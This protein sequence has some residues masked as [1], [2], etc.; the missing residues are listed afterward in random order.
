M[1]NSL[2][3]ITIAIGMSVN[4]HAEGV[5]PSRLLLSSFANQCPQVVTRNVS[6]T[7]VNIQALYGAVEEIKKDTDCHGAASLSAIVGR[8]NSLYDD[9]ENQNSSTVDRSKLERQIALYATLLGDSS[10]DEA[11]KSFL[12]TEVISAQAELVSINQGLARFQNFS[13]REARVA[14]QLVTAVDDF[15]TE[16]QTTQGEACYAKHSAQISNI[17]SNALLVTAAF[18]SGGTS[19]A[20]A[21]GAV[22]VKSVGK[23]VGDFKESRTMENLNDIEMPTALRCVSQALS[24]QFCSAAETQELIS[25]RIDSINTS[26]NT[27]DGINLLS[28]QLNPLSK[29]LVEVYSGSNITS[30]GDLINREK[31]E[32]QAEFLRQVDKYLDAYGTIKARFFQTLDDPSKRSTAIIQSVECLVNLFDSPSLSPCNSMNNFPRVE[33]PIFTSYSRSL[34]AYNLYE[35]GKHTSVPMCGENQCPNFST[36]VSTV[37]KTTLTEKD[38]ENV[39]LEAQKIIRATKELVSIERSKVISVD[40]YSIIVNAKR[41]L[42]GETSPYRALKK[43]SENADRITKYLIEKRKN[44]EEFADQIANIAKTKLIT[45]QIIG[46]VDEGMIPRTIPS[47]VLPLICSNSK[48]S[49][50]LFEN[51]DLLESKSFMITSCISKLLKLQERGTDVYFSKVRSMVSYEMEARLLK[52]DLGPGVTD[53]INSTKLD[54]VQSILNSYSSGRDSAISTGELD[55]SLDTAQNISKETMI[56]FYDFFKKNLMDALESERITNSERFDLCFRVLPYLTSVKDGVVKDIYKSCQDAQFQVYK[57]GPSIK[58]VDFIKVT[59]KKGLKPAK[60]ELTSDKDL[61]KLFCAYRDYN[62]ANLLID[63]QNRQARQIK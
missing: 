31:P 9:F 16:L 48:S 13:G 14:N 2:L 7:L 21:G 40:A 63:E 28:Y 30:E 50:T 58:F 15:F 8:Y 27:Y 61:K 3:A 54:L 55:I 57:K 62:R 17:M 20:L 51:D 39:L 49:D 6:A 37:L 47:E 22:I 56:A 34:F 52:N 59:P 36:Y 38:W 35:P 24:D 1:L 44:E 45:T 29:W 42:K 4:A 41:E 23:Y 53:L 10:L 46:L 18:A 60:Y 43:I 25:E 12:Q 11:T 19:L 26:K 33:N 32:L 5:R